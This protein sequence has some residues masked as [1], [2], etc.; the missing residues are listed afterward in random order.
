MANPFRSVFCA[1]VDPRFALKLVFG[2]IFLFSACA[3]LLSIGAQLDLYKPS[4]GPLARLSGLEALLLFGF[5][6]LVG[7][8]GFIG[9]ERNYRRNPDKDPNSPPG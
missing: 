5:W 6:A 9:V 7:L 2:L 1:S 8:G 4:H 3:L